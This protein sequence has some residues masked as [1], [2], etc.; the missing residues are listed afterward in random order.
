MMPAYFHLSLTND[1]IGYVS[2]VLTLTGGK[3]QTEG[4]DDAVTSRHNHDYALSLRWN[5]CFCVPVF[6]A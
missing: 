2:F 3:E 1:Y 6:P 4:D 5:G